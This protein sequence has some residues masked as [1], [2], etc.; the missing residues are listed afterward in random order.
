MIAD[1]RLAFRTLVKAPGFT[2]IAVLTL[3]LGIGLSTSAFSLTNVLL[4]RSLPYPESERLVQDGKAALGGS[5]ARGLGVI[6]DGQL[7]QG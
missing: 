7:A 5:L 6:L 4:F 2:S 1:L 3:A